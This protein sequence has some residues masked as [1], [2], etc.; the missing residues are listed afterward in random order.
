[1]IDISDAIE[2]LKNPNTEPSIARF[3]Q[4]D[5]GLKASLVVSKV[6]DAVSL[7]VVTADRTF[8]VRL[9]HVEIFT[10]DSMTWRLQPDSHVSW[11]HRWNDVP[12]RAPA[13][14]PEE[15]PHE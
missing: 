10:E 2:A 1:M 3:A 12:A 5:G 13:L 4:W 8:S 15:S 7:F 9:Q 6:D 14:H 11:F